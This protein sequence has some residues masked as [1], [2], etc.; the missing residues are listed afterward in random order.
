MNNAP[1]VLSNEGIWIP[2]GKDI[3]YRLG[4]G[5]MR[6]LGVLQSHKCGF[7]SNW[8]EIRR[9]RMSRLFVAERCEAIKLR[10]DIDCMSVPENRASESS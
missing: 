4:P 6:K 7:I 9:K 5:E 8:V 2:G 10:E 1:K 3:G